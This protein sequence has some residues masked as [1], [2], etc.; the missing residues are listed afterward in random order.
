MLCL[1]S[2][3]LFRLIS[4]GVVVSSQFLSG[5]IYLGIRLAIGR[6]CRDCVLVA[7]SALSV[8]PRPSR[9]SHHKKCYLR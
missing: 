3:N 7:L 6:S 2:S 4:P 9:Y 8:R 5:S 1:L